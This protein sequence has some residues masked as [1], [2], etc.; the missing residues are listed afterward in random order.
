MYTRIVG[1]IVKLLL[2][3]SVFIA[4]SDLYSQSIIHFQTWE[5]VP[6]D[7]NWLSETGD[8]NL[9]L[10]GTNDSGVSPG[11]KCV[12]ISSDASTY[13]Y[14]NT[15]TQQTYLYKDL[16]FPSDA[17]LDIEVTF[18][19][20]GVGEVGFDYMK[21]YLVDRSL[22][23]P[24]ESNI[25]AYAGFV[26][27]LNGGG[28][29]SNQSSFTTFNETLP[30]SIEGRTDLR[31]VFTWTNNGSTTNGIPAAVDNIIISLGSPPSSLSG[32]YAVG[33]AAGTD[34]PTLTD[35]VYFLNSYGVSGDVIF[36]LTDATYNNTTEYF[37][38]IINNFNTNPPSPAS[39]SHTL[40]IR[41]DAG[42][43]STITGAVAGNVTVDGIRRGLL[44]FN[45]SDNVIIDGSNNGTTS[46][47]LTINNTSTSEANSIFVASDNP[48]YN[49]NITIKNCIIETAFDGG[50]NASVGILVMDDTYGSGA[51]GFSNVTIDNNQFLKGTYGIY[52]DGGSAG[53]INGSFSSISDNDMEQTGANAIN[54][55]GMYI[56]GV[57][58][59][60]ISGNAIGNLADTEN[61][62]DYGIYLATGATNVVIEKNEIYNIGYSGTGGY[63]GMGIRIVSATTGSGNVVRNN[64]IYG[65]NGN[66]W[67]IASIYYDYN[68]YAILLSGTQSGIDILN[69]SIYLSGNT[70]K[71]TDALSVGIGLGTGSTAEIR[72]NIIVNNLGL[73]ASTGIGSVGIFA[74]SANTQFEAI[75]Y[76]NYYVN[77]TGNGMNYIGRIATTNYSTLADWQAASGSDASSIT[78]DPGYTSTSNLLPDATNSNSWHANGTGVQISTITEDINGASRSI[79]VAD[80]APDM[81]AYEFTPSSTPPSANITGSHTNS[82]TETFKVGD[83]VIAEITWG[84]TGTLPAIN[85]LRYY[86]G[87]NP[88]SPN[89]ATAQYFNSYV[90]IDVTGGSGYTYDITLYYDEALI[91]TLSSEA[92]IRLS[93]D[94]GA[95]WTSF[96]SQT[97][98]PASNYVTATGLSS[99]SVFT[100]SDIDNLLPV[101][102]AWFRGEISDSDV[103]LSWR[104]VSEIN[105]DYFLVERSKDAKDWEVLGQVRGNGTIDTPME[106]SFTDERPV[107][108]R[109]YYRLKQVDYD[110]QFEYSDVV[111]VETSTDGNFEV[112]SLYPNPVNEQL[113]L[114][115]NAANENIVLLQVIDYAGKT[116]FQ[117]EVWPV[118]GTNEIAL[119]VSGFQTGLYMVRLGKG[120]SA[121]QLK[122]VKE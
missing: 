120:E 100:G 33:Q 84:A 54:Q 35:A 114:S 7:G 107:D 24:I 112:I 6:G 71:Q 88:P 91:G 19:W 42:V 85:Y 73:S 62:R 87:A 37:P 63:T 1:F 106:Y 43:T 30:A 111:V 52:M 113:N 9:W 48:N 50:G 34:F 51:G 64:V 83:R 105:N 18:D 56:R 59:G 122:F 10:R 89:P 118:K 47:D 40:T 60:T 32:E 116:L 65:I 68:P 104:T 75:N 22:A 96:P 57:S 11:S 27:E 77:A 58:S 39:N 45:E 108:G 26:Y 67:D 25:E 29:F 17:T 72:N 121:L 2:F 115:F 13:G 79:T 15:I 44:T 41:P 92:D 101:E 23:V 97:P 55:L 82:G 93:K 16:D 21:V 86:S 81:G 31:L 28:E 110:G 14:N 36:E 3:V 98:T 80:G 12:Y 74:Q 69:N 61:E 99:F 53:S 109:A 78:A 38:I 117:K 102:L 20:K 94:D 46:R 8:T 4:H 70:I 103:L 49:D 76:N 90:D 5:G 119:D 66:G 95:G